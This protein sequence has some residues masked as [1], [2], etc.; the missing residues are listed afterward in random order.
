VRFASLGSGSRGNATLVEAGGVRV[1]VD[2]GFALCE[3]ERRL[4]LLGVEPQRLDA[5]LVTHE[6]ADH[7]R[8]V[9]A[10]ARR[11]RIPVWASAG[12]LMSGRCGK[13]PEARVFNSHGHCIELGGLQVRPY[14]VPHDAREP[15]QAVFAA[16]GLQLG[17]LTDAGS[18]TQHIVDCLN[19]CDGLLLEANHDPQMLR[20]G[21]YP[22]RLQA[23]VGGRYGHLSNEQAAQLLVRLDHGRLRKVLVGHLSEK[24]NRPELARNRLLEAVPALGSRLTLARQDRIT[25]WISL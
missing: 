15:C 10:L 18:I 19:G 14:P 7:I 4:E 25:P 8:G 6:H 17:L 24:N 12:T 1:L 9:G 22:Q 2:C 11:Y 21:P 20:Q 16:D 3:L 13:L 5:V 23:R